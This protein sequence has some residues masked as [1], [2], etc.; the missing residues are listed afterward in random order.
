MD[1]RKDLTFTR[2][3]TALPGWEWRVRMGV[4]AGSL[5]ATVLEV[6]VGD[7]L[8]AHYIELRLSRKDGGSS[9]AHPDYVALDFDCATTGGHLLA[10][11]DGPVDATR[12]EGRWRVRD[13][14]ATAEAPTLARAC[15]GLARERGYWRKV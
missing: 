5:L 8:D 9:L 3:L 1:A 12:V 2:S 6:Y 13:E 10:L 7:W 14:H 11:L 4:Q 15:A